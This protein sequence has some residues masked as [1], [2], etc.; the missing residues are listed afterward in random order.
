MSQGTGKSEPISAPEDNIK[1]LNYKEQFSVRISQF[2]S[3]RGV[4]LQAP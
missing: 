1:P 3:V 2:R 4:V